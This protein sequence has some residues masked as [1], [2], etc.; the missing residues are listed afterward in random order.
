MVKSTVKS[1]V[2]AKPKAPLVSRP[3]KKDVRKGKG[4]SKAKHKEKDIYDF[5]G[6]SE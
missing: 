6:E 1:P 5:D 4:K 3:A 2:V